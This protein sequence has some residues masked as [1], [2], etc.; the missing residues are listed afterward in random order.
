MKPIVHYR[1]KAEIFKTITTESVAYLFALDHPNHIPGH[2]VRN[3]ETVRTSA[4]LSHDV[5]TGRIETKNTIYMPEAT[6]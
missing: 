3:P 1:G 6:S 2:D 4:V 5:E